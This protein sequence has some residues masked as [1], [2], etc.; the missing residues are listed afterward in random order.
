MVTKQELKDHEAQEF[1]EVECPHCDGRGKLNFFENCSE[2]GGAAVLTV[3]EVAEYH[4]RIDDQIECPH[5][6]GSGMRGVDGQSCNLCNG[7]KY[8]DEDKYDAYRNR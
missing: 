8:V 2:C 4:E 1:N 7:E 6:N 5:C 3:E